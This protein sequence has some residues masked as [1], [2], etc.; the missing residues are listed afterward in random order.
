MFEG[1]CRKDVGPGSKTFVVTGIFLNVNLN[2]RSWSKIAPSKKT[3]L[4]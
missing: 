1:I 4:S 3:P 2:D